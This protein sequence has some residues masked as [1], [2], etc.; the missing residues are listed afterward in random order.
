MNATR[1][2]DALFAT[3]LPLALLCGRA[4]STL[5]PIFGVHLGCDLFVEPLDLRAAFRCQA[6]KRCHLVV[7][8]KRRPDDDLFLLRHPLHST[9]ATSSASVN[10]SRSSVHFRAIL[11]PVDAAIRS[12]CASVYLCEF[13]V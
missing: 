9:S 8:R 11:K 13:S 1:L 4:A 12:S 2:T 7:C 3:R 6:E 10:H 5:A